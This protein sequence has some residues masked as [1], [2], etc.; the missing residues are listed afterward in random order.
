MNDQ[1]AFPVPEPVLD[2]VRGDSP[3]HIF[4]TLCGHAA[5]AA[6]IADDDLLDLLMAQ[7]RLG[8]SGIGNGVAI[9]HLRISGLG[10]TVCVLARLAQKV[11]FNAPDSAPVDLV[12][13]LLSP[14]ESGTA[15]LRHLARLTRLFRNRRFL[16]GMRGVKTADGM[17]ALI[18]SHDD[19]DSL[20]A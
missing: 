12:C 17:R 18:L 3:S 2:K 20:A 1:A 8:T 7:E 9:P 4:R 6:G 14:E 11:D 10:E 16:A 13:L 15:H 19:P 5:P